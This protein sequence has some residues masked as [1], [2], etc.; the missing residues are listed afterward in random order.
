MTANGILLLKTLLLSS[1]QRNIYRYTTDK[2]KRTKIIWGYI[3][4]VCIYA[5]LVGYAIAM[6][7]GYG[8]LGM[9]DAAPVLCALIISALAFILTLFQTNGYLFNFK[10]YDK[11]GRAHV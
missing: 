8:K 1:S 4:Q 7:V 5:M 3:G 2:K 9:I 10:E 11:I 6:C